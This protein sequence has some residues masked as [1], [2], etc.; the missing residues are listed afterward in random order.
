MNHTRN[1]CRIKQNIFIPQDTLAETYFARWKGGGGYIAYFKM[2]GI[3]KKIQTSWKSIDSIV[4]N[5]L[6]ALLSLL[7]NILKRVTEG[8]LHTVLMK[9]MM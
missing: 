9:R 1:I 5:C 4:S 8:M 2:S 6:N 7:L 3:V